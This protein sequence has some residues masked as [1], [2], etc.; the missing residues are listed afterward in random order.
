MRGRIGAVAVL[1]LATAGAAHAAAPIGA[2][3]CGSCHPAIYADWKETAHA[4]SL[5]R[6]TASEQKD[7]ACRNC[8]T[9]APTSNEPELAGVQCE[10]CHGDGGHYAPDNVMRDPK[11]ARLM[12]LADIGVETCR[13]CHDGIS[14]RIRPSEWRSLVKQAGHGLPERPGQTR[15]P[16]GG[17]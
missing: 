6:L 8:H 16:G 2:A 3:R 7:L 1:T 9:L 4:R 10:S 5:A 12:G 13:A 11:L 15:P 17:R 14:T